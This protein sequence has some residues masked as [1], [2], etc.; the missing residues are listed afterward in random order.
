MKLQPCRTTRHLL[1]ISSPSYIDIF[2]ATTKPY[3]AAL[4]TED[5]LQEPPLTSN[6][7]VWGIG[8]AAQSGCPSPPGG[9]HL[10]SSPM[11]TAGHVLAGVMILPPGPGACWKDAPCLLAVLKDAQPRMIIKRSAAHTTLQ[12]QEAH[13][14]GGAFLALKGFCSKVSAAASSSTDKCTGMA[15]A[16][17]EHREKAASEQ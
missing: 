7:H 11:P 1:H 15:P 5:R 6:Q 4:H 16:G 13:E 3:Y 12:E 9:S 8:Q 14:C 17:T 10:P 2:L